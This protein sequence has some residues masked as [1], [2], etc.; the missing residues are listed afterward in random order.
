MYSG[1]YMRNI[2][3]GLLLSLV[4]FASSAAIDAKLNS[5]ITVIASAQLTDEDN[6]NTAL[7]EKICR[8]GGGTSC[9]NS[10]IGEG[11]CRARNGHSCYGTTIEKALGLP[12]VDRDWKW[13]KFRNPNNYGNV[14]SCR[15]TSTG[16]FTEDSKCSGQTKSDATW[17]NN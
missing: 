1:F 13:D 5:F 9:Y 10:S 8:A 3:L 17:P 12:V 4:S 11:I 7:G 15:G 14:W 16:Q 2:T 6:D